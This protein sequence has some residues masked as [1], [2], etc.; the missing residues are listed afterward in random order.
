MQPRL[1][2]Y[3]GD[4]DHG[5]PAEVSMKLDEFAKIIQEA[6][7]WDS[8]WLHDFAHDE[9]K[10]SSDLYELISLYSSMRPTA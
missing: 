3:L 9:V 7:K 10:I 4:D 5:A 2:L 6:T 1:K 8:S